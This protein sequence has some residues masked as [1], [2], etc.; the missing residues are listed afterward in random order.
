MIYCG[1][2]VIRVDNYLSSCRTCLKRS[3][4]VWLLHVSGYGYVF[5]WQRVCPF[6]LLAI[7]SSFIVYLFFSVYFRAIL[8]S[9]QFLFPP[10]VV[11]VTVTRV[12]RPSRCYLT[13]SPSLYSLPSSRSHVAAEPD[14]PL[15]P[16][17]FLAFVPGFP[18]RCV[19]EDCLWF[20]L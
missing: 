12:G 1:G 8:F 13:R 4:S 17:F 15:F 7:L 9:S 3:M 5:F 10:E 19:R 14:S 6:S 16:C 11:A 20:F 18:L 2:F